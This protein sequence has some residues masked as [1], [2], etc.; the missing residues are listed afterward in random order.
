MLSLLSLAC[1]HVAVWL[2]VST[3]VYSTDRAA[4]IEICRPS[5]WCK[6][7]SLPGLSVP[8]ASYAVKVSVSVLN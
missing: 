2:L 3:R 8:A 6:N 1:L 4:S 7:V 5:T